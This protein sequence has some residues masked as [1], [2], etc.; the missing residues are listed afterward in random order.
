MADTKISSL[1][2]GAPAQATDNTLIQRSSDNFKLALSD[3]LAYVK[4]NSPVEGLPGALISQALSADLHLS[5]FPVIGIFSPSAAGYKVYLPSM[6]TSKILV[7]QVIRILNSPGGTPYSFTL[8]YQDGTAIQV[9]QSRE[10]YEFVVTT[11]TTA[12]GAVSILPKTQY[13]GSRSRTITS[14]IQILTPDDL[15]D[16]QTQETHLLSNTALDWMFGNPPAG[17]IVVKGLSGYTVSVFNVVSGASP[18]TN[19]TVTGRIKFTSVTVNAGA[20]VTLRFNNSFI[21][22]PN[23]PVNFSSIITGTA[24]IPIIIVGTTTATGY[25]DIK[26]QNLGGTNYTGT[27]LIDF[28][29][30][31]NYNIVP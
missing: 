28:I 14:G 21:T 29:V 31:T 7:G 24:N 2:S 8:C 5:S 1:P 9:I 18:L 4:A 17:S 10:E 15:Q 26:I 3:L 20:I 12:N 22:D 27:I 19:N 11:N 30:R 13:V 16:S 6:L 25:I 23:V